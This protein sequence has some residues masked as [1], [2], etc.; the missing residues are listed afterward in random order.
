LVDLKSLSK[1]EEER[2]K[3]N[4]PL[5]FFISTPILIIWV[6]NIPHFL[7]SQDEK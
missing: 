4:N 2:L 7:Q 3:K 6:S 5:L 1:E